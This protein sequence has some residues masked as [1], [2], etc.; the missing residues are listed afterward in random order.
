MALN[1]CLSFDGDCRQ[2]LESYA[3]LLDG[4]VM[5]M[6]TFGE[7]PPQEGCGDIPASAKDVV[8]H[9]A[10]TSTGAC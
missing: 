2:A 1:T 3:R 4:K 10:S 7:L 6:M 5:A 8:M 9:G